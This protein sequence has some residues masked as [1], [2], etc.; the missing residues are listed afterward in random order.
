[1]ERKQQK[2]IVP[3]GFYFLV[4]V[5]TSQV[6]VTIYTLEYYL[7]HT[8]CP[9]TMWFELQQLLLLQSPSKETSSTLSTGCFRWSK[10]KSP[11]SKGNHII[12]ASLEGSGVKMLSNANNILI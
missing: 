5:H 3:D 9:Y 4:V 6:T 7:P 1:M 11:N 10:I 8:L 2:R 12:D